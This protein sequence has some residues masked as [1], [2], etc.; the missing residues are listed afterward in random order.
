MERSTN[1]QHEHMV[2]L[3]A[4]IRRLREELQMKKGYNDQE[5][6]DVNKPYHM[7][8]ADERI[9]ELTRAT[10]VLARGKD[11]DAKILKMQKK[12]FDKS[13]RENNLKMKKLEEMVR[14]K[15]K[16]IKL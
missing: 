2:K 12:I 4:T 9:E 13:V 7:L 8:K 11:K 15:D 1:K 3:N 16:E 14:E 6:P 5:G 10:A